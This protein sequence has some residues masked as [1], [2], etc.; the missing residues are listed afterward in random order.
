MLD[1]PCRLVLSHCPEL[2]ASLG[3][4]A[5]CTAST[6]AAVEAHSSAK[7]S[8]INR[9]FCQS[10]SLMQ[11]DTDLHVT[12]KNEFAKMNMPCRRL[13]SSRHHLCLN[14]RSRRPAMKRNS[15]KHEQLPRE[16]RSS[17]KRPRR[18]ICSHW[19]PVAFQTPPC[20]KSPKQVWMLKHQHVS[21]TAFQ[22]H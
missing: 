16:P 12:L 1:S 11:K 10:T 17:D 6:S 8:H 2:F 19:L 9:V 14:H 15:H 22:R 4:L 13:R 20:Q 18:R 5:S 7:T 3:F 21:L